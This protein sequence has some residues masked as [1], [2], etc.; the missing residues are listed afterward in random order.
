MAE[1]QKG[2]ENTQ[3]APPAQE[4][5]KASVSA[6]TDDLESRLKSINEELDKVKR[7][8]D[9]Y[10]T[11]ALYAKGKREADDLDL[12]DPVQLESYINKTVED[13]LLASKEAQAEQKRAS[14]IDEL[15]RKNK[16]MAL[17]LQNKSSI[18]MGAGGGSGTQEKMPAT[19][20]DTYWSEEQVRELKSRGMND[21][22]IKRAAEI[23][24]QMGA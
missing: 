12:T 11:A 15:I 23:A 2:V 3:S 24:R 13:R 4:V 18:S 10:R 9:N 21:A 17:A 19:S 22:Q 6:S 5:E 7:D 8:R 14:A 1:E 16:E 20:P